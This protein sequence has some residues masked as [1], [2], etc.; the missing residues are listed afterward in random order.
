M[1]QRLYKHTWK[2]L[3]NTFQQIRQSFDSHGAYLETCGVGIRDGPSGSDTDGDCDGTDRQ[4]GAGSPLDWNQASMDF[5]RYRVDLKRSWEDFADQ[6]TERKREQRKKINAWIS[7]SN[8]VEEMQK[9]FRNMR[10][11]GD[12]G[13][14]IFR[15][16][17][18]VTGWMR[19]GDASEPA[20]WLH[21][22][23]GLGRECPEPMMVYTDRNLHVR[24]NDADV[25]LL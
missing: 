14:W 17:S 15:K 24:S 9:K 18:K 7:S 10:I 11:C 25:F 2:D 12:S 8:K 20:I 5:A 19:D 21:G 23:K 22:K 13:R 16:Y 1:W 6:E 4:L 3:G